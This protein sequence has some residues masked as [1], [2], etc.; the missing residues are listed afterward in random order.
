[1]HAGAAEH[2][3]VLNA[4]LHRPVSIRMLEIQKARIHERS[5]LRA[6]GASEEEIERLQSIDRLPFRPAFENG[7]RRPRTDTPPADGLLLAARQPGIRR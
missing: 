2:G 3:A 4:S 5:R 7:R 6:K 1:M